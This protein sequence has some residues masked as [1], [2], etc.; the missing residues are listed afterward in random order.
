MF[1]KCKKI[2]RRQNEKINKLETALKKLSDGDFN[3][4][5]N[6]ADSANPD[7][8]GAF[9]RMGQ[10][11]LQAKSS[12]EG[13]VSDAADLSSSVEKGN[14]SYQ[15]NTGKYGGF[16]AKV[17]E[18]LNTSVR[19]VSAPITQAGKILG[20]M[21]AN[22]FTEKMSG[23]YQGD[24]LL[25]EDSVNNLQKKLLHVQNVIVKISEGNTDELEG[26]QKTGK[27][28]END[29]LVPALINMM[30]TIR[31]LARETEK[32]SAAAVEGK[33]DV[34]GDAS[35]F[36]GDY[37]T[38]ING[39]NHTLDAMSVPLD[40][41]IDTIG[42]MC[43]NDFTTEMSKDFKGQYLVLSN[44][45][46]T[47]M[48][49]LVGLQNVF[50]NLANGDTSRVE[51][52]RKIGKRSENDKIMP[53]TIAMMDTIRDIS[54]ETDRFTHEV[55]NG[56]IG[57]RGNADKFSGEFR[58]IVSGMNEMLDAVSKPMGE[59]QEI[60]KKMALNDFTEQM[61]GAYQGDFL[62]ISNSIN[63]VQKRL[64][65]AQNVAVKISRGDTSELE[66]FKKIGRRSENDHLVPAFIDMM[67][68]IV[69]LVGETTKISAA[70]VEGKLEVRGE[71]SKF[72][73]DYVRIINGINSTLD[74]VVIPIREVKDVM[75]KMAQGSLKTTV[76]GNYK[77]DYKIMANCVNK[78]IN[79]LSSTIEQISSTLSR[80]A[81]GDLNI[82]DIKEFKGDYASI[83][84][85]LETIVKSLNITIGNINTAA[86]Q[87]AAGAVQISQSSQIL[88]Q[89][90]EEQASAIEEVTASITEL[91]EQVKENAA[92]AEKAN[93]ISL[94]AS[95]NA[96]K[97]NQQMEEMLTA[98][99]NINDSSANISKIIKVIE[100]IASQTNILA[101]NA[102]VEAARAGQHGKGFAV[103][104]EEVR[105]LAGRSASAAKETTELIDGSISKVNSGSKM[106]TET[107]K[108]LKEIVKSI[109]TTSEL[110]GKIALA[111]ND[112]SNALSQVDQAV[113]QVSKVIQ[114]NSATAVET[115]ASSEELS[116]QSESL[117]Q[118][119][120]NFK[121]KEIKEPKFDYLGI[122]PDLLNE[123][124]KMIESKNKSKQG[125]NLEDK[126]EENE[127]GPRDKTFAAAEKP[128]ICLNDSEFGKY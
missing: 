80:I 53:A 62:N 75:V 70:A 120:N 11:L 13:L 30:E 15:I 82:S 59:T 19:T 95:T 123:I 89:G 86:E 3:I 58:E 5:V 73:G 94:A 2:L 16:Y 128:K 116:G 55:T 101:L 8:N 54:R 32:I 20:K 96:E 46:N 22:D 110:V 65:S 28:S 26:F 38:I 109:A 43:S 35:N 104:A 63:D 98:M 10:Y 25:M 78:L 79:N 88:S 112:Q 42:R 51:D 61:S 18:A 127:A 34:R 60:L 17:G 71:T 113:G 107:A 6:F 108:S 36:R 74:A 37:V 117:K 106:A 84:E 23:D 85:S 126:S 92:N 4:D 97:G 31:A 83:S 12:L 14:L 119:I 99:K 39:I 91:A 81:Q 124:E 9:I 67:E 66:N 93:K 44:S 100:D 7:E 68:A 69:E 27:R 47:L 1:F 121:L 56:N 29:Q 87:V 111:S 49:R 103:V 21:A 45:M 40:T 114:S 125:K 115:A 122:D 52:Y 33:L 48:S 72:H 105:K 41:A 24:I 64:L 118:M 102:A 77:G 76:T 90:S 50:M 57:V